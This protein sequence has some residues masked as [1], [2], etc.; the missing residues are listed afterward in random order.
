MLSGVVNHIERIEGPLWWNW[1]RNFQSPF[2]IPRY[3]PNAVQN[4]KCVVIGS[5]P[6]MLANRYCEEGCFGWAGEVKTVVADKV[7]IVGSVIG[8]FAD[9]VVDK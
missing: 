6:V 3:V 2:R 9:H 4:L 8:G 7:R 1:A 5:F